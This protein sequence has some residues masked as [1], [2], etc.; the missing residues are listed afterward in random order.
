MYT[1]IE[2]STHLLTVRSNGSKAGQ[3]FC[4]DENVSSGY[5]RHQKSDIPVKDP[6]RIDRMRESSLLVST[7]ERR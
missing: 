4:R 2:S 6:Y 5:D 3:G 1:K 7:D